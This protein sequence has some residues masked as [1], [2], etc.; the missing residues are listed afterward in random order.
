M[1]TKPPGDSQ[2]FSWYE[3]LKPC[4]REV[5]PEDYPLLGHITTNKLVTRTKKIVDPL[6]S[7]LG[8]VTSSKNYGAP[9]WSL[10][11]YK[12]IFAKFEYSQPLTSIKHAY[13]V[14]WEFATQVLLRECEFLVDSKVVTFHQTTKNSDSTPAYPKFKYFDTEDDYLTCHGFTEYY[15]VWDTISKPDFDKSPLWWTFLKNEILSKD[16]I[17]TEDLRMIMCTDPVFTRIGARFEQDQNNRMKVNTDQFSGQMGWTPFYGGLTKTLSRFKH[18]DLIQELDWTRFDGTIPGEVFRHIK[19]VRFFLLHPDY[20]TSANKTRYE[21]YCEN[22][23]VKQVLLPTGEVTVIDKGNPSGQI[24]TTSDNILVNVF[25]TA[26]EVKYNNPNLTV[27]DYQR[28]VKMIC[29]GDDRILGVKNTIRLDTPRTIQMYKDIFG[30]WVKPEKVKIFPSLTGVSFCGMTFTIKN[31][32]VLASYNADK[33]LA[34]LADPVKALPDITSLWGKLVSL[35]IL[36][37]HSDEKARKK[38]DQYI[39][40]VEGMM[41]FEGLTVPRLPAG[42]FSQIW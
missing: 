16:K 19:D 40:R 6:L 32:K 17:Q 33:L 30:M 29:Y 20:K 34:S 21:W 10:N 4:V 25:L 9:V 39:S 35:R 15:D 14:E 3:D 18:M 28:Q 41:E 42:F 7:I 23:I 13:P 1:N 26:F 8:E 22:L 31:G 36:C 37:E 12:N 2:I 38:L 24:S 27:S 11:A 5:V